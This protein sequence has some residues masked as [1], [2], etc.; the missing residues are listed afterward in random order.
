MKR[1]NAAPAASSEI[2]P[3]QTGTDP[4]RHR[5][6]PAAVYLQT[7]F[8]PIRQRLKHA[9]SEAHASLEA[10]IGQ[11]NTQTA[12]N[13][14]VRGLHAFRRV[15]EAW[16]AQNT[17]PEASDWRP[18]RLAL[19]LLEDERDL[20]LTPLAATPVAWRSDA[21][22]ALGVHYVLEGSAL[23]AR[24]LCKQVESLG[25]HRGHGARHLWAQAEL[26]SWRNFLTMLDARS[27]HI[28][29]EAAIAGANAAFNAA[30]NAMERA[31]H[32]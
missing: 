25:M 1:L 5:L 15:A 29:D 10:C 16:L 32:G 20:S 23:G 19:L 18:Q 14:Y 3:P 31:T 7:I 2:G 30:A 21:S 6:G 9:T 26:L 11:L 13:E 4:H 27:D 22:F 17:S 28:D 24:V 12:Y 8:P